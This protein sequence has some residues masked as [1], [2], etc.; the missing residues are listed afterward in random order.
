MASKHVAGRDEAV[1][2][3]ELDLVDDRGALPEMNNFFWKF[4]FLFLHFLVITRSDFMP[5][6]RLLSEPLAALA[7]FAVNRDR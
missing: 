7:R 2:V 5:S 1:D 4:L 6:T 3:V